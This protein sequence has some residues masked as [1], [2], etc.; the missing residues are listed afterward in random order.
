MLDALGFD[1][2][3]RFPPK[4][5]KP[6]L[7]NQKIEGLD[8]FYRKGLR[9]DRDGDGLITMS[10]LPVSCTTKSHQESRAD[11]EAYLQDILADLKVNP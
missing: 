6:A 3:E 1:V 2:V 9:L 5:W 4:G 7:E 11:L 10:L 8:V